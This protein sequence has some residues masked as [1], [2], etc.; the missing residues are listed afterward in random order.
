MQK[1]PAGPGTLGKGKFCWGLQGE[2]QVL[3]SG[4]GLQQEGL[5]LDSKHRVSTHQTSGGVGWT[6]RGTDRAMLAGGAWAEAD[7]AGQGAGGQ[8]PVQSSWETVSGGEWE[9][10]MWVCVHSLCLGK[11]F[12]PLR[13]R[14]SKDLFSTVIGAPRLNQAGEGP[15]HWRVSNRQHR[16]L[17]ADPPA[18][19]VEHTARLKP[20]YSQHILSCSSIHP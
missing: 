4:L 16:H 15:F 20:P 9:A 11:G 1:P 3:P 7:E 8:G 18:P 5:R 10:G 13:T 6:P 2:I 14:R 12:F 17:Q 19:N